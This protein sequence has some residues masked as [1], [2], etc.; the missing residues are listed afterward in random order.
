M[1]RKVKICLAL[2]V[3]T[4]LVGIGLYHRAEVNYCK[5]ECIYIAYESSLGGIGSL[6]DKNEQLE[7]DYWKLRLENIYRIFP[8]QKECIDYCL[9]FK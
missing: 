6:F 7:A 5:K 3:L 9:N 8:T 4:T 1:S 2:I